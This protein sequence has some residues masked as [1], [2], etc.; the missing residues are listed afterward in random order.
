M[1]TDELIDRQT[2]TPFLFYKNTLYK[3]IQAEIP[4]KIS[5]SIFDKNMPA[6]ILGGKKN[7]FF[8][9]GQNLSLSIQNPI[10][11][12]STSLHNVT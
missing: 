8:Y 9:L 1:T 7:F 5:T 10:T 6:S 11:L 2:A 4:E 12:F 3:N